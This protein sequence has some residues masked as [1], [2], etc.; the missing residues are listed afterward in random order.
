M[1][2]NEDT[3]G[4][5]KGKNKLLRLRNVVAVGA[6]LSVGSSAY[7]IHTYG[8]TR[9]TISVNRSRATVAE[10]PAQAIWAQPLE[11]TGVPN[12]H[13]IS[14]QLYRG[15]QP[16]KDG[17]LE[18]KKL[19]IKT[20]INLR[21]YNSD[22]NEI[23]DSN[24]AYERIPMT[25]FFPRTDDVIRFLKIVTDKNLTPV[26]V[27]CQRGADRTGMMCAIYRIVVQNWSKQEAVEEM[28]KGGFGYHSIWKNLIDYIEALDIEKIKQ[29]AGLK[30]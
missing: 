12:L 15:G 10:S 1:L 22:R 8:G 14:D 18:L 24:F 27:H 3:A 29:K 20:I 30:N 9:N 21:L 25:A 13:R 16:T 28:T 4:N 11:L 23:Q 26:Y 6:I 17:F 7:F 2:S 5:Q 19:G